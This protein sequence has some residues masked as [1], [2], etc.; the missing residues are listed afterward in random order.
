MIRLATTLLA[1]TGSAAGACPMSLAIYTEP[2]SGFELR[3]RVPQSWEMVGQVD[4]MIE[5][6]LPDGRVLWG[7]IAQN[8]GVSRQEG[9]LFAG[10]PPP[11]QDGPTP[12][13]VLD[14]CQAWQGV[15]YGLDQGRI[16]MLP[17]AD[18][19]APPS[20]I[21][22]DFGRQLRY[23]VMDGPEIE[24]WDQLDLTACAE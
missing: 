22:A 6:G 12:Q 11:S 9:T 14:E 16:G 7:Q 4:H 8:M 5:L 1:L 2:Q 19:P 10:C 18:Q 15:V 20:L 13:E 24:I 17:F 3:F 21:L 23:S